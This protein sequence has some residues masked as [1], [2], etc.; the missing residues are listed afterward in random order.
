MPGHNAAEPDWSIKGG[1]GMWTRA[2]CL[3]MAIGLTPMSL[4]MPSVVA[5]ENPPE[6]TAEQARG[7]GRKQNRY[8]NR[9]NL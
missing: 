1:I 7:W 9:C 2:W 5:A 4:A 3:R 6:L 8:G